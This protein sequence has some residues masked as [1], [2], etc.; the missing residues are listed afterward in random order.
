MLIQLHESGV[1]MLPDVE[2][3]ADPKPFLNLHLKLLRLSSWLR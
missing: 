2:E 3:Y 1:F